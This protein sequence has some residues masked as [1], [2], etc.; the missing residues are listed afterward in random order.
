MH[1][2]RALQNAAANDSLWSIYL[3]VNTYPED[4]VDLLE[5]ASTDIAQ[6]QPDGA[7]SLVTRLELHDVETRRLLEDRVLVEALLGLLVD[8]CEVRDVRGV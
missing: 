4:V 8:A 2:Q 1:P 5:L 3:G 7:T 6:L